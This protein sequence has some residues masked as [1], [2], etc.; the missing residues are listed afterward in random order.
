MQQKYFLTFIGF[1][2]KADFIYTKKA[3][4]IYT[5]NYDPIIIIITAV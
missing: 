1:Y 4:F 3:D 2:S 5:K